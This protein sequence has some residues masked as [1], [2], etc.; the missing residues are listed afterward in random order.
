[1]EYL[2]CDFCGA[3]TRVLTEGARC[4][5]CCIGKFREVEQLIK[6]WLK[7]LNMEIDTMERDKHES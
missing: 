3:E 7:E 6:E 2:Q 5:V 4:D 1:M